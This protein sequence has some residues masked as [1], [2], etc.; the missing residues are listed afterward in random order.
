[1]QRWTVD[2]ASLVSLALVVAATAALPPAVAISLACCELAFAASAAVRFSVHSSPIDAST[3]KTFTTNPRKRRASSLG[4]T[5]FGRLIKQ[6]SDAASLSGDKSVSPKFAGWLWETTPSSCSHAEQVAD[7]LFDEK[8]GHLDLLQGGHLLAQWFSGLAGPHQLHI[9]HVTQLL[10]Y[11]LLPQQAQAVSEA[12]A[13]GLVHGSSGDTDAAADAAA[14]GA[15]DAAADAKLLACTA[16]PLVASYR[17]LVFYLLTE[18]VAA[19]THIALLVMGFR[20]TATP[21]GTATVYTWSPPTAG[22]TATAARTATDIKKGGDGDGG[23]DDDAPLLFLHGIGLGLTPYLRLLRRL[24]AASGGRRHVYAVQTKHVSMRLTSTIPAPHE[25]AADVAAFLAGRGVAR[26]S[27]LAHSYGT[28]I[29]SALTKLAAATST[30]PRVTRLTLVDPVCFAMFLPHLV[31]NAIYQQPLNNQHQQ[32]V[33]TPP[34]PPQQPQQ[35][36]QAQQPQGA[37]RCPLLRN[38]IKGLVVAEFHCSVALRRRLDWARVNLWPSELP[39]RST[40][41]LSGRDNLVPVREVRRILANRAALLGTSCTHPN[42]VFREDLGHGGFLTDEPCQEQVIAAALGIEPV[43]VREAIKTSTTINNNIQPQPQLQLLPL[44][45]QLPGSGRI[46][47]RFLLPDGAASDGHTT[48][49]TPAP[50]PAPERR[51]PSSVMSLADGY[52][53][54]A[55]FGRPRNDDEVH[56]ADWLPSSLPHA[57]R[58]RLRPVHLTE[59]S[60]TATAA[61]IITATKKR[62]TATTI[63][64]SRKNPA[65]ALLPPGHL[66]FT[67]APGPLTLLPLPAKAFPPAG[68]ASQIPLQSLAAASTVLLL[69]ALSAVGVPLQVKYPGGG[70]VSGGGSAPSRY[71]DD[72]R[73]RRLVLIVVGLGAISDVLD[74][75][76]REQYI[77][78]QE[79]LAAA[80]A[81]PPLI[82]MQQW[83]L[84]NGRRRRAPGGGGSSGSSGSIN[85]VFLRGYTAAY[86]PTRAV[87][88]NM[89]VFK[90]PLPAVRTVRQLR[91]SAATG[92]PAAGRMWLWP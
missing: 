14:A 56:G 29:A 87:V 92:G 5:I 71:V 79:A 25:V 32:P 1:M 38:L 7:K 49:L 74:G 85:G 91:V 34:L 40:V 31:R 4:L 19:A 39:P 82:P 53:L 12:A 44:N 70:N 45:F 84:R 64:S 48:A 46:H 15:V 60:A 81:V 65:T 88:A 89:P 57:Q 75:P 69:G 37:K 28:L 41:V 26:V 21:G 66:L 52:T 58:L 68:P 33:S 10:S 13:L 72:D 59:N 50:A 43:R 20:A 83:P 63:I 90:A 35:P 73:R 17:P 51:L 6:Q 24:L 62:F 22:T 80:A 23:D 2:A 30:A 8:E 18:A 78:Q 54:A 16:D 76:R 77:R 42:V 27:L 11:L 67:R 61:A 9:S 55:V 36:H 47:R 3:S 86:R